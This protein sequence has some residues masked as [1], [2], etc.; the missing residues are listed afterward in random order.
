MFLLLGCAAAPHAPAAEAQG[1]MPQG[2]FQCRQ[3]LAL[4]HFSC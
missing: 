4:P 3:S 2:M 1:V